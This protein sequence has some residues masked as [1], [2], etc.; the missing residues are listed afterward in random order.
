MFRKIILND[1]VLNIFRAETF[2]QFS[3]TNCMQLSGAGW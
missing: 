1:L 2:L 3:G